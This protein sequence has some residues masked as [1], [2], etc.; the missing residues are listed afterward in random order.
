MIF[1]VSLA[2]DQFRSCVLPSE[3][4][5]PHKLA[6]WDAA[7]SNWVVDVKS[8]DQVKKLLGDKLRLVITNRE[9]CHI[10]IDDLDDETRA[11]IEFNKSALV[12]DKISKDA[13]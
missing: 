11:R 5:K 1:T 3:S 9:P 12:L 6:K 13:A 7:I 8:L 4:V 2:S 10:E